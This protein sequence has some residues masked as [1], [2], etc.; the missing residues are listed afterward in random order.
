[1]RMEIHAFTEV[2]LFGLGVSRLSPF[3]ASLQPFG[4]FRFAF[5]SFT[6]RRLCF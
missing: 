5:E 1:M 4:P 6:N 2:F 3:L